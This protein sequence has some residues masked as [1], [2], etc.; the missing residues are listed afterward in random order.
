MGYH[1]QQIVQFLKYGWPIELKHV[2]DRQGPAPRN[3]KGA[4]KNVEKVNAY[5]QGELRRGCVIGSFATNPLE[6]D[7]RF[8]PLDAIPKKDSQDLC[9]IMNLPYPEEGSSINEA[10]DKNY[11]LGVP[12]NLC[13]PGIDDL[14]CLIQG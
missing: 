14:M 1:D 4:R 9:I 13:Y 3:Q 12:T 11:Y 5:L 7:A 6:E 8:S 10:I 2:L